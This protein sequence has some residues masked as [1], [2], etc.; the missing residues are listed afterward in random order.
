MTEGISSGKVKGGGAA[1]D[2]A[3]MMMGMNVAKEMMKIW[4]KNPPLKVVQSQISV[5]IVGKSR[6]RKFLLQL[7]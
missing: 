6:G 1:S 5:P 7:W 3:G 4:R 2:M